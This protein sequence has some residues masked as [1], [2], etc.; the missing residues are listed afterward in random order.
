METCC[1][2]HHLGRLFANQGHDALLM[3]P[4][5]VWPYV[6]E[7]KNDGHDAEGIVEAAT[8]PTMRFVELKAQDQPDASPQLLAPKPRQILRLAKAGE[9]G[10]QISGEFELELDQP[11]A[12]ECAEIVAPD[13]FLEWGIEIFECL[14]AQ[15]SSE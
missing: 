2:A 8:P 4:E 14:A 3:S 7:Q 13:E 5:Y 11:P 6:K 12:H 9:F 10:R 1:G 15:F